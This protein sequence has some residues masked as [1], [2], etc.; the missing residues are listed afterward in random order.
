MI[1]YAAYFARCHMESQLDWP[2]AADRSQ[3][4]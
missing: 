3:M 1:E 2:F 4:R